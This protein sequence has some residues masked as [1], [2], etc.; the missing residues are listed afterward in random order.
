MQF[1]KLSAAVLATM[2]LG[3]TAQ[4]QSSVTLYGIVDAS[5]LYSS[6]S[7]SVKGV[8]AS[9]SKVGVGS[10]TYY[11]TL[12]GIKGVEDLGN[13][14]SAVFKL[15]N[16]FDV[17]N[18]TQLQSG[19]LFGR[20]ATVGVQSTQLGLAEIGR[21][22]NIA[23]KYYLS[24]DPFEL[25]YNQ[26]GA[27]AAFGAANQVRYSNMLMYQSPS[28][29]GISGG[30]GYSFNTGM[31][32][33]YDNV[34][35]ADSTSYATTNNMRAA[36]AGLKYTNGPVNVVATYD[37]VMPSNSYGNVST[38]NAWTVG[39]AYDFK[40]AKVSAAYGQSRNG[41]ISG[42]VPLN[43]NLQT[44][45]SNGGILFQNGAG[46][47]SYLVG[48]TVPVSGASKAMLSY[49][50]LAPTGDWNNSVTKTQSAYNLGYQY[51]F[52]KRTS[53]YALVSYATNYAMLDG[54]NSTLVA[55]GMTHKF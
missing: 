35:V 28:F 24:I 49:T 25:A 9:S 34:V 17:Q 16:G 39:G 53:A 50:G 51:D 6:F 42:G 5:V 38:V 8:D 33:V 3:T 48:A 40:V 43:A 19:R 13:G 44:S 23:S 54:V 30:I 20:Q 2:A 10:G 27:G 4:A 18:G 31:S 36:T 1:N 41:Y 47:N 37:A 15:E 11:P 46:A 14:N 32:A 52:S 21:Q 29:A 22:T 45:W 12:F 26:V 7:G 55:V